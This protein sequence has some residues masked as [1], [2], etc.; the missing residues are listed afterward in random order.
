MTIEISLSHKGIQKAIDELET[1]QEQLSEALE[2]TVEDLTEKGQ[3]AAEIRLGLSLQGPDMPD[4]GQ[5]KISH[6]TE[7]GKGYVYT[8]NDEAVYLEYGTGIV[9]KA[10]PHE[11]LTKG[12]SHP[13]VMSYIT[14]RGET[15][16]YT[17]YDTYGHGADGWWYLKADGTRQ[18]TVGIYGQ[19]FMY[20]ALRDLEEIAPLVFATQLKTAMGG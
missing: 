9:G 18:H 5:I 6:H 2:K 17:A 11:G 16:L 10:F 3:A 4:S 15:R 14:A 8:N 12:E 13:P 7:N 19:A 1:F 20:R